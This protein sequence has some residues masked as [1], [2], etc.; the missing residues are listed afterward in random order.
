MKKFITILIIVFV[1]LGVWFAIRFVI[2][3]D[4]DTWLCQNGQWVQHGHPSSSMP[5]DECK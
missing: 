4:E 1:L 3:G 2:G 5:T